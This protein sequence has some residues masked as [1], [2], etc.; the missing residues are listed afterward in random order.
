MVSTIRRIKNNY[1]KNVIEKWKG[2]SGKFWKHI[3]EL[4]GCQNNASIN[5]LEYDNNKFVEP[6]DIAN[7]LNDHFSTVANKGLSD[8]PH[9]YYI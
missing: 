8:L 9:K 3:N 1:Y 2:N 4:N 7:K 5:V 6:K